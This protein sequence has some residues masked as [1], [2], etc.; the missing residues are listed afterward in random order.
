M[1]RRAGDTSERLE[2]RGELVKAEGAR[3]GAAA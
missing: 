3:V 1:E 2:R